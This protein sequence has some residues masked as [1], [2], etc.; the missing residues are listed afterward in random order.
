MVHYLIFKYQNENICLAL[1]LFYGNNTS[2][3]TLAAR[4]N[5]QRCSDGSHTI[6]NVCGSFQ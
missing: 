1:A 4:C 5:L 6:P 3:N 2:V